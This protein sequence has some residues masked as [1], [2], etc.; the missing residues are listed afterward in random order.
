MKISINIKAEQIIIGAGF[1]LLILKEW[2]C[3]NYK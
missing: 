3:L 1:D 2:Y